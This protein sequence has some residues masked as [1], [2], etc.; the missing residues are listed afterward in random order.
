MRNSEHVIQYQ[1]IKNLTIDAFIKRIKSCK[2][3]KVSE[4]TLYDLVF[5]NDQAI[6]TGCGVYIFKEG[7]NIYYIGKCSR[8]SFIERIPA[9]FDTRT[10]AWFNT[11]VKRVVQFKK[12]E[13]TNEDIQKST[14]DAISRFELVLI[15]FRWDDYEGNKSIELLEDLLRMT[16]QAQNRF[17]VKRWDDHSTK[18]ETFIKDR[19]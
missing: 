1:D 18:V 19:I 4:L 13:T 12:N 6:H 10:N 3:I 15:N 16:T 5:F 8:R 14:K 2:G 17:K 11:L 7:S 9:H